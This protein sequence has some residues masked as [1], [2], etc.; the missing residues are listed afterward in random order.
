MTDT[1]KIKLTIE[2]LLKLM[3]V[4]FDSVDVSENQHTLSQKFLI[5]TSDSALLIGTKGVNLLAFNHI[6]KKIVSAGKEED[7]LAKFFVDVNNYQDKLE[8]ELK[9]KAKIMSDRARSFKV[10]IELDPMSS[11]ERMIIHSFLQDVSDIKTES[12]GEGKDRRVVIKYI[13]EKKNYE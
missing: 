6:I 9:N 5:K 4:S 11:Y 8:E 12:K 7:G 1:V 2:E 13:E 10:D 3:K